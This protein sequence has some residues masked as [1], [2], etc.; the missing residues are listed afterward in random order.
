MLRLSHN[1]TLDFSHATRTFRQNEK[2]HKANTLVAYERVIP[3]V[4]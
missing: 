4:F 2:K 3:L 1:K